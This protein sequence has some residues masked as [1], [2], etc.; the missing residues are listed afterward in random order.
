[1][2]EHSALGLA[3]LRRARAA[4]AAELG[5]AAAAAG[6]HPA[7][8]GQGATF[9]TLLQGGELRGCM[10]SLEPRRRLGIDV[11]ENAVA[12]AFRDPRFAPLARSELAVTAVEVSLLGP[13]EAL[14]VGSEDELLAHLRPGQDGLILGHGGR[15][16]TFLPQVWEVLPA[17]GDFVAA[18]KRKAGWPADYW[19]AT[20]SVG[21]YSVQKWKESDFAVEAACR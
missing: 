19:D 4:I 14:A 5:V 15:R 9:V 3:L 1:M 7:F 8:A 2:T 21:R 6:D 12:A 13:V 20:M 18:L 16:A 11:H 17:P 10:G